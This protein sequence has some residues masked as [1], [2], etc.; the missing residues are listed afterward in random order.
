MVV[1]D[2]LLAGLVAM[3]TGLDRV[4][5]VQIM[6]SRPLVAATLTGWVLGSPLVGM[7]I[8]MLLEYL[9]G[10]GLLDDSILVITSDHGEEFFEHGS[11]IQEKAKVAE[12]SAFKFGE[13][14]VAGGHPQFDGALSAEG[15]RPLG[16]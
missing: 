7:E 15:L 16:E 9:R 12:V 11:V 10:E 13:V 5:L 14:D 1:G 6:I 4:A 3:L 2:Y 8:G